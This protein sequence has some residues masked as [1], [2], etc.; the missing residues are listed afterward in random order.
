MYNILAVMF[1]EYKIRITSFTWLFYDLAVPLFY[2]LVF[3]IGLNTAF[4]GGV[5]IHGVT[6][7]YNSFF[8]A[9]VLSMTGF[10]IAINTSYGFFVDRD[11]GIFYEFLSYPMTRGE[12]LIGK[13]LFAACMTSIQAVL[14]VLLGILVLDIHVQFG[15]I[16]LLLIANVLCTAGWFFFLTI[17]ALMIKRNDFYNTVINLLYF[18]L[19][20][21]SSLF[22]PLDGSPVWLRIIGYA[23]P[24]SWHTDIL[25][26]LSIGVGSAGT[27]WL[28]VAGYSVFSVLAFVGGVLALKRSA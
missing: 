23:N 5:R 13:I 10:G 7:N 3:G 26:Y 4:T 15:Y 14:S 16:P 24:L 8:L 6:V 17:F 9:G 1:R 25:R 22:F 21:A 2:L 12:F 18:V 28:E 27:F 20:F 19:M 11:N